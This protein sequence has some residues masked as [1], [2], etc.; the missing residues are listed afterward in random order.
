MVTV[1]R[2]HRGP[3]PRTSVVIVFHAKGS[4]TFSAILCVTG[5]PLPTVRLAAPTLERL[6]AKLTARGIHTTLYLRD[7]AQTPMWARDVYYAGTVS[8]GARV[9]GWTPVKSLDEDAFRDNKNA[10]A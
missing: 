6:F 3:V 2:R 5:K 1:P 9:L 7:L 10:A 8:R 4:T